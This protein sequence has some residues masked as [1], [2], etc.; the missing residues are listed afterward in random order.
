MLVFSF[1][2]MRE[3][4]KALLHILAFLITKVKYYNEPEYVRGQQRPLFLDTSENERRCI[5]IIG[6]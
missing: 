3:K 5:R 1:K 4:R 2:T 6:K